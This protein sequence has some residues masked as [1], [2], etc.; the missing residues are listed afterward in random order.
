VEYAPSN[1]Q[2]AGLN[3]NGMA[4]T[5]VD[6]LLPWQE[7]CG[8][9][10][11]AWSES[12]SSTAHSNTVGTSHWH[13]R[14][15]QTCLRSVHLGTRHTAGHQAH[16]ASP[17]PARTSSAVYSSNSIINLS[18]T[19]TFPSTQTTCASL[20]INQSINQSNLVFVKRRLN[21]VLR[22]TSYE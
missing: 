13:K 11:R 21:K 15:V 3:T 8:T 4:V 22:G 6:R 10:G 17:P 12:V 20:P 9:H 5:L 7:V 2:P 14:T 16:M 18:T 1:V 19:R